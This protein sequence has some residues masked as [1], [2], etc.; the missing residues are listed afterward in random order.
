MDRSITIYGDGKQVRDLLHVQDLIRAYDLGIQQI[1]S[2]CGEVFNVG[3]GPENTLSIWTEFGPLLAELAGHEVAVTRAG[4]RQ[5]YQSVFIAD[6][7]KIKG[8][9]GWQPTISPRQGIQDLYDWVSQNL[10]LF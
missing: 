7:L 5:G 3:G 2:L 4:W 10:H 9:L 6:I 8:K 1:E